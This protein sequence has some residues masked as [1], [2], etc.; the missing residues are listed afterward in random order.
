MRG[1]RVGDKKWRSKVLLVVVYVQ[2]EPV[3]SGYLAVVSWFGSECIGNAFLFPSLL[4]CQGKS[5]DV[6]QCS[7]GTIL[8][9]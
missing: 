5:I 2:G 1:L 4:Y 8:L 6:V 9:I 3:R 7:C